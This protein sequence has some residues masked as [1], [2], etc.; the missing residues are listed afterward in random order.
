MQKELIFRVN[1]NS[2]V[3]YTDLYYT[4]S[5][6]PLDFLKAIKLTLNCYMQ[7]YFVMLLG[8]AYPFSFK[9]SLKNV[10]IFQ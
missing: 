8:R 6:S 10:V 3:K 2:G 4:C 5:Y 1:C 9:M 7:E